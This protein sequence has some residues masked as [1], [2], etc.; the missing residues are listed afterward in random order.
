MMVSLRQ[1]R[2]INADADPVFMQYFDKEGIDPEKRAYAMHVRKDAIRFISDKFA[3]V[4]FPYKRACDDRGFFVVPRDHI[5]ASGD[6]TLFGRDMTYDIDLGDPSQKRTIKYTGKDGTRCERIESMRYVDNY[7][8]FVQSAYMQG[9]NSTC[10]FYHVN[11]RFIKQ[12]GTQMHDLCRYGRRVIEGSAVY[13]R[14]FGGYIRSFVESMVKNADGIMRCDYDFPVGI[15]DEAFRN[16]RSD[17]MSD[18]CTSVRNVVPYNTHINNAVAGMFLGNL[19]D[20][21]ADRKREDLYAGV[22]YFFPPDLQDEYHSCL[23]QSIM[24]KNAR[25]RDTCNTD[26]RQIVPVQYGNNGFDDL[27]AND[28]QDEEEVGW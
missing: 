11:D 22:F 26:S 7:M 18:P 19:L 9:Y 4:S 6:S 3:M 12:A 17:M 16:V 23:F 13:D 20:G 5:I 1:A 8:N 14:N 15:F 24:G 21:Y 27:V 10:G 28:N 25:L 2:V